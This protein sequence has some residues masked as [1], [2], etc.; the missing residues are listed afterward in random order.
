MAVQINQQAVEHAQCAKQN[1][2]GPRPNIYNMVDPIRYYGSA[3]ELHQ[4]LGRLRSNVNSHSHLFPA[5]GFDDVEYTIS[6]PDSWT[7]HQ[8]LPLKQ[9][10]MMHLLALVGNLSTESNHP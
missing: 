5:S 3:Q 2:A 7:S 4:C 10:A 8:L 1:T 9:T 6:V